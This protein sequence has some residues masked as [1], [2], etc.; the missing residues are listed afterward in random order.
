MLI[1]FMV[2]YCLFN[3]CW[4]CA[5]DL[6]AATYSPYPAAIPGWPSGP[7]RGMGFPVQYNSVPAVCLLTQI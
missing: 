2:A 7:A 4:I 6:F 3:E 5:Q 1:V